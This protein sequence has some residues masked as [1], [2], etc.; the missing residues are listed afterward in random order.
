MSTTDEVDESLK[1][2][3]R[4]HEALKAI[5][6]L[7]ADLRKEDDEGADWVLEQLAEG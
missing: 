3:V 1:V 4:R 5:L 2:Q 6:Q 7:V